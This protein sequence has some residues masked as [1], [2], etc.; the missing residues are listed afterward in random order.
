MKL[1]T[2][3]TRIVVPVLGILIAAGGYCTLHKSFIKR[4]EPQAFMTASV[5]KPDKRQ[6]AILQEMSTVLHSMDTLTVVTVSGTIRVKDLADS[7]NSTLQEFYY[8]RQ[9]NTG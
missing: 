5:A 8:S 6:Q 4:N 7:S 9:G 3:T 2:I 1:Q